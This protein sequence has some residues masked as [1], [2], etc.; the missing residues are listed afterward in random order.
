MKIFE[1]NH[2]TKIIFLDAAVDAPRRS[3]SQSSISSLDPDIRMDLEQQL[4]MNLEQII[5][6]YASY[7]HYILTSIQA[8]GIGANSFRSYL[9]NLTAFRPGCREQ[10]KL[11]SGMKAELDEADTI[12]KIFD[13]VSCNCASFFNIK[14]F[15]LLVDRFGIK[16]TEDTGILD[17]PEHLK[18]YINMHK[19]S[20]FIAIN[21]ALE[22]HSTGSAKI[23]FKFDLELTSKLAKVT[24]LQAAVAKILGLKASTLQ[25]LS[26]EKGCVTVTFHIPAEAADILFVHNK[27]F[28][29]GDIEDFRA[30]S[31]LWLE[32]NGHKYDFAKGKVEDKTTG[33][34]LVGKCPTTTLLWPG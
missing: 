6:H 34:Y 1:A 10:C 20:E 30:L 31:V 8:K 16:D 4:E 29:Q 13:L 26:I 23:T 14:I 28:T 33:D 5:G 15:Q 22:K 17:Y 7:A 2:S 25:L 11:L 24:K 9:L 32:C 27:E 12:N 18:A 3:P 21:P 19:I